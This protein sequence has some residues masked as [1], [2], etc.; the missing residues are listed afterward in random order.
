MLD[1][2]LE[3]V[4]SKVIVEGVKEVSWVFVVVEITSVKVVVREI[5][6]NP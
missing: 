6:L 2:F 3:E 5:L 4:K 1:L